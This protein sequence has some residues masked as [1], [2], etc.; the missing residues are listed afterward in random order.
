MLTTF[1][2]RQQTLDF[3]SLNTAVSQTFCK[4]LQNRVDIMASDF[5]YTCIDKGRKTRGLGFAKGLNWTRLT[6]RRCS[7]GADCSKWITGNRIHYYY[8]RQGGV[9]YTLVR[10]RNLRHEQKR[11]CKFDRNIFVAMV[12]Q[13]R[14]SVARLNVMNDLSWIHCRSDCRFALALL[15]RKGIA[16]QFRLNRVTLFPRF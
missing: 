16:I 1:S 14:D 3:V 8:E 10:H 5:S 7:D 15:A 11:A 12:E 9:R 6:L 13:S 2:I 4:P